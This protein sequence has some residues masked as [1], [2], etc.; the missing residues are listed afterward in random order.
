MAT[1]LQ[2]GFFLILRNATPLPT[3]HIDDSLAFASSA[4]IFTTASIHGDEKEKG[5]SSSR[6]CFVVGGLHGNF[7]NQD[8]ATPKKENMQQA[9]SD[10]RFFTSMPSLFTSSIPA[11]PQSLINNGQDS[12]KHLFEGEAKLKR[13]RQ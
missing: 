9:S 7:T 4:A 1:P 5:F 13:L 11:L 3:A 6:L 10:C 8:E 2:D 12:R